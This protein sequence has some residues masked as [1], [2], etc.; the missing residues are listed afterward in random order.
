MS[1]PRNVTVCPAFE[2]CGTR[3]RKYTEK[4]I[5]AAAIG[6][7]KPTISDIQPETNATPFPKLSRRKTYSPPALGNIA[8]SSP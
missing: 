3:P 5:D 8:P 1:A 6:R 4:A 2:A 7:E